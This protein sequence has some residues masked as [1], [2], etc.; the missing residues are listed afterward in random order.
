MKELV[1][2]LARALVSHPESVEVKEVHSD[3]AS[4]IEL[5][6]APDD[7]GRIIGK[8][9]RTAKSIRTIVT[10]AASRNNRKV[11][12]EILEDKYHVMGVFYDIYGQEIADSVT[13]GLAGAL[14]NIMSGA[15]VTIDPF[16]SA[17]SE[18]ETK[19]NKYI[20]D[21]EIAQSGQSGVPTEAALKGT[22][23]RRKKKYARGPRRPS[24]VFSGT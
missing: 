23:L 2:Y 6:V 5:R 1:E 21:E 13:E 18:I 8:Q 3:T 19:F 9:G 20:D 12:L 4:I 15:P 17:M 10:A 22:S 14:E 7:L 11:V 24:F 16:G